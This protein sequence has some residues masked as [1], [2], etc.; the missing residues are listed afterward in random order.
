MVPAGAPWPLTR[1]QVSS[2]LAREASK[3]PP[4]WTCAGGDADISAGAPGL[5]C[6][7]RVSTCQRSTHGKSWPRRAGMV[8]G[9]ADLC[10]VRAWRRYLVCAGS[11]STLWYAPTWRKLRYSRLYRSG[12]VGGWVG[13]IAGNATVKLCALFY[14]VGCITLHGQDKSRC[15]RLC[16]AV[17]Q[18]GKIKALHPQ[19]MQGKRKSPATRAG[20][21]CYDSIKFYVGQKVTSFR[22]HRILSVDCTIHHKIRDM[23]C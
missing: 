21:D 14:S 15:K 20:Y 9:C 1:C 16:V 4:G 23:W 5:Y 19:Q 7:Q 2:R 10:S 22:R 17:L 13:T 8:C 18:Q 11:A 3:P 12:I 6:W